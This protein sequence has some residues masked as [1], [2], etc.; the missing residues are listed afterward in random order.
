M[1]VNAFK[2]NA[3]KTKFLVMGTARRL[4][5]M[6]ENL[7][8]VME[9][10]QLE[11][12]IEKQTELLGIKVQCNLKW[13]S[14]IEKLVKKLQTRLNGLEKIKFA[15]NKEKKKNIVEGV[16]N[17]VLCYCLPLFEDCNKAEVKM[18]QVQ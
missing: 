14:Q 12:N 11:E 15:M 2:L 3:D 1:H 10:V 17:S 4:S 9:G 13:S 6:V 8:V 5:N 18:L 16:F 7:V